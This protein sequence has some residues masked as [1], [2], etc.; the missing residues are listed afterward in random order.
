MARKHLVALDMSKNE[1]QNAVIQVLAS[2][3]GSPVNGQMYFNSS[4]KKLRTYNGT[5][6]D[7]YGTG[8]GSGDVSSIETSSSDGQL[9]V[10]NSTTGKSIKKSTLTGLLK[11]S[12]GVV[13]AAVSGTDYAPATSGSSPLKGNGSGGFATATM[14]DLSGTATA[15][16]SMNS[17]RVT[18]VTDPSG[19]QD[20]ATKSYVDNLV[21]GVSWKQAVR[22]A[23]TTAGTL[24]SS[25]ANASVI[26]GVTLATGDRILIKDQATASE[27]GIY[28]VNASGAPTRA[29]DADTAAEIRQATV[30]VQEGTANA[31]STWTLTN[32]GTIT[33]GSTNLVFALQGTGSVPAATTSVAGKVQLATQAEAEAKSVSTKAV[34]PAAIVNFPVKKTFTVGDGT[35]TSLTLTHNLNTADVIVQV[36]QASDDA[37]VDCDIDT[38][39]PNSV[40]LAFATAPAS[41]AIKAVV[42]G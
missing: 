35:S 29:A 28:T 8:A 7:E 18:N 31:D 40:V 26:D 24:A 6:W 14:S 42:I 5:S 20:A 22:A 4:T 21:N 34:T 38:T 16:V 25:F 36:R 27:N 1:I 3:P 32:D 15:A 30:V 23:T 37:V 2:D 19:A 10:F 41:N 33:L 9:V 13:A 17:Q 39:G 11:A 12:S